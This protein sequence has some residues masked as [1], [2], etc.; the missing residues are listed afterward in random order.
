MD[1]QTQIDN[2]IELAIVQR[3][4][5]KALVEQLPQLREHLTSEIEK[6][7]EAVEPE[8]RQELEEFFARKTEER[9][10][11][12]RGEV[13]ERV[14]E[15]LKSL[16]LAAAA[17]YHALMNE[18]AKNAELLAQAEQRIAEAAATIPGKVKEIVTDELSRF[19]RAG[20]I[21]QLRKEFAEP[22][23]LNPRGKWQAGVAYNKLDLVTL[24]GDS[25]TSSIDDNRTRPSRSSAD[26]TLIAARGTG[27]AGGGVTSLTDLVPVPQNGELLIG[28]GS[29]FVNNT[30]TA[31]TGITITNGAGSITIDATGAQEIL[32]ATVKNAESVA[33]TK[34][35]VVYLFSATGNMPSVKLAYNTSD[36]TSAKTFGV[37]SDNSIAPNGTG[38]VTCVGV[39]DKLNLGAYNDGDTVYLGATPGSF[40]ATKPYA[41]NH[42]VYVGITE[43]ANAGNGELYVKIQNGYELDE[44][45]DVQINSPRQDGQT[46]I[47]DATAQLWKN[48]RLT[49]GVGVSITNGASAIT[50]SADGGVNYQGTWN[51]STN[52]PTLTSSVGTKGFYYVV[53]VAGSTNLNG[54]T[55]WKVGDWAIFNGTAW[56]KVDTTDQVSSVF[57]RT[58]AVVGVSTDYSA[59]GITNTAIGASNPSTGAFTT[60]SATGNA[61]VGGTLTVNGA[62][63]SIVGT[64]FFGASSDVQASR[65]A[66]GVLDVRHPSNTASRIDVTGATSAGIGYRQSGA[67]DWFVSAESNELRTSCLT[68]NSVASYQSGVLVR[69]RD[70]TAS[71]STSTGALV[72]SGGVGV[73]GAVNAGGDVTVFGT[74]GLLVNNVAGSGNDSKLRLLQSGV[75]DAY[76]K[77]TATSGNIA[78]GDGGG[79]HF[80]LTKATGN[81]TLRGNLTAS[82]GSITV[83]GGAYPQF[84]ANGT[85]GGGFTI[86]KSGVSYGTF[87][88]NDSNTVLDSAGSANLI[89]QTG[90]ATRATLTSTATTLTGNLTV[91]GTGTSSFAGRLFGINTNSPEDLGATYSTLQINA[92]STGG[93]AFSVYK[94]VADSINFR[95][96]ADGQ[97]VINV[98]SNHPLLLNTN[99]TERLR[100]TA[101]GNVLV[102]TTT[103]TGYKLNV[104]GGALFSSYARSIGFVDSTGTNGVLFTGATKQD[105]YTNGTLALTLNSSQN[106]TLAGNLTV[107]GTGVSQIFGTLLVGSQGAIGAS[108]D[109]QTASGTASTLRLFQAGVSNWVWSVP[110]STDALVL[111]QYGTN[112]ALRI[113]SSR[114]LGVGT[115]S[116]QTRLHVLSTSSSDGPFPTSFQYSNAAA[117]ISSGD[118][119]T[120]NTYLRVIGGKYAEANT[121]NLDLIHVG[122]DN[123][124]DQGWRVRSGCGAGST[125]NNGYLSFVQI[126]TDGSSIT[127]LIEAARFTTDGNLLVGTTT[128]AGQKLQVR[129]R[130]YFA[131]DTGNQIVLGRQLGSGYA[132]NSAIF[133]ASSDNTTTG[134][135]NIG[136]AN[137]RG[138]DTNYRAYITVDGA[139]WWGSGSGSAD[140]N[141]YR[142]A[143]AQLKTD[144]SLA[145]GGNLTVS[146]T[147][148]INGGSGTAAFSIKETASAATALL[149]TNR[150]STQ[151]WGIAV[152]AAVVDDKQLAFISGGSVPLSLNATTLAATLAGNLTVNGTGAST[153]NG[154]FSISGSAVSAN[155]RA[156]VDISF[157]TTYGKVSAINRGVGNFPLALNPEGGS[158]LVNTT[159]NSGN[160]AVQLATHTTSAG[161]IGFG[162]ETALYRAAAG[163]LVVD[164]IGASA[165]TLNLSA[166]GSIQS[167]LFFNGTNTFLESYTSHS[168]ILR[169]NQ[170]AAL[171]LDSSQNATFAK[172]VNVGNGTSNSS[173]QNIYTNKSENTAGPVSITLPADCAG[174]VRVSSYQSGVGRSFRTIPFIN[175]G[176]TVTLGTSD[177]TVLTADPVTSVAAG[178]GAVTLNL[179]AGNT[180]VY[181][182][183]DVVKT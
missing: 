128:D 130:G 160:G 156:C 72:V 162:T 98:V 64:A 164:H 9:V 123:N 87:Y 89:L 27:V 106:A 31:G 151:T 46:L 90:G 19:P 121:T 113:N 6:T 140:T 144:H 18:R 12:L 55:D 142:N 39:V 177:T 141:L 169:T 109:V 86:Q 24:N 62:S 171:T 127:D 138:S 107:S 8:L 161:G 15:M 168:L 92:V 1:T 167:R 96:G 91:S 82:G 45:H 166:N 175:F 83:S 41:P 85:T 61:T 23:S 146:G 52:S 182:G 21:D 74:N 78:I 134:A 60:L 136:F 26:W 111:S 173:Y 97:G 44:I 174:T 110:A 152:D 153:V 81:G 117:V 5:L 180:N 3:S 48:A 132:S 11:L 145:V 33:I 4:E 40:T 10:D 43:R 178:T 80:T 65:A 71:T 94:N 38:T 77:N 56:E 102:G 88:G 170:T 154:G 50:I 125:S 108:L 29:A 59:V 57:G 114:N 63:A 93:G 73:A 35:Q 158:V 122:K 103:D 105:F 66:A 75:S 119:G 115:A 30:L 137:R 172:T 20:E 129:G 101:S 47:Y 16:E 76:I 42:L 84:Y 148:S 176:G 124:R 116:P 54:V 126:S 131:D 28:N 135:N 68:A 34:G 69:V 53:S 22:K 147:G 14:S 49:A 104:S 120:N 13:S 143:A 37:V 181:W 32:T 157:Q 51:A 58:G 183:I 133:E 155:N 99:N 79:D 112:E 165:P 95:V 150:N 36:A 163:S 159:T 149:L 7:F 2:L 25:Y 118:G 139:Y 100:V 70:T 179:F 67:R 17:K